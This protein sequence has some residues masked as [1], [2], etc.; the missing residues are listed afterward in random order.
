MELE[1]VAAPSSKFSKDTRFKP[2]ETDDRQLLFPSIDFARQTHHASKT[3]IRPKVGKK[4]LDMEIQTVTE[5]STAATSAI[6]NASK[7]GDRPIKGIVINQIC[8]LSDK[9]LERLLRV[10]FRRNA[11]L[12]SEDVVIRDIKYDV[13]DKNIRGPRLTSKTTE[14]RLKIEKE[15]EKIKAPT[16]VTYAPK[17][18]ITRPDIPAVSF[19]K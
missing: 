13:V 14:S 3:A 15:W 2:N 1:H 12:F 5:A 18:D 8:A 16:M 17:L 7:N 4:Q 10:Q 6:G 19:P 11:K 9:Q